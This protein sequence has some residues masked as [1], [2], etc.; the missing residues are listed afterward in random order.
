[1]DVFAGLLKSIVKQRTT[2]FRSNTA[3]GSCSQLPRDVQISPLTMM[4]LRLFIL[5][6][7]DKYQANPFHNFAHVSHDV[8]STKNSCIGFQGV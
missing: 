5:A 4:Q 8:M 1:V 6:I 2:P 3:G 7:A